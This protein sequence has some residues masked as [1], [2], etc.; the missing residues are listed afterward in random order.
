MRKRFLRREAWQR[1]LSL[2]KSN[3]NNKEID[4]ALGSMSPEHCQYQHTNITQNMHK[5]ITKNTKNLYLSI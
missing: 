5:I 4:A 3:Y 1:Q 2:R